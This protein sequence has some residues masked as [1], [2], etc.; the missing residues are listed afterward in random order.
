MLAQWQHYLT[1]SFT[2]AFFS[3]TRKRVGKKSRRDVGQVQVEAFSI[4]SASS[5][6]LFN[7]HIHYKKVMPPRLFFSFPPTNSAVNSF[8]KLFFKCKS[9]TRFSHF[10][11]SSFVALA[12]AA[13]RSRC[14]WCWRITTSFLW[15]WNTF[16]AV[17]VV[18]QRAEFFRSH[19]RRW[20]S[21]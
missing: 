12:F 18:T 4:T 11:I 5:F 2:F 1:F 15:Q 10:S 6:S 3:R 9:W 19:E 8:K 14:W 7:Y 21:N 13:V 16:D 20:C 17:C